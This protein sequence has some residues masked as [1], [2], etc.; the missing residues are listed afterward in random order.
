MANKV[1]TKADP[2]LTAI[3]MIHQANPS[4]NE[5]S[6]QKE[7]V[8]II[9][10]CEHPL[11]LN[12][13]GNNLRLYMPQRI[14]LK[15]FYRGDI[16]NEDIKIE[17]LE[18]KWLYDNEN[19]EVKDD[20]VYEKNIKDVIKKILYQEKSP[21]SKFSQLQLVLG[22]RAG[23]TLLAS[24]ITAY[25]AYKLL[26]INKGD[27]HGYYD[28][29][30]GD[31]IS[32][33]NVA[34]SQEQAGILFGAIQS[35]LRDSPFFQTR[36]ASEASDEIRLYTNRDIEKKSKKGA[37]KTYGSIVLKCGHS[38]PDSLAGR[39]A[40]LLLFDEIAYFDETGKVTGKYFFS[41]LKPSLSR[42]YDKKA[43]KI[44]QISSPNT[45]NGV[46]FETFEQSK[47]D[48]G[49]LSFQLPTWC[50][51][52]KVTYE[53]PEMQRDRKANP[54]MFRIEYGAQWATGGTYGNFFEEGMLSR[55]FRGDIGP[56][57]KANPKYNYYLHIDPAKKGNN[58]SAVL[59]A[60]D[61][62]ANHLGKRR[63]RCIL[64]NCWVWRPVPGVGLQFPL[65]DKDIIR[66]CSIFHPIMV[67]YDD[68]HSMH[69]L[70]LLRSH[71]I[72]TRQMP[73]NR[74]VKMKIYQNLRDLM[75]Y[76]PVPE[77]FLYDDGATSSLLIQELKCLKFKRTQRG[78]AITPDK[79]GDV[80]TDDLADCLAGACSAANE[81]LQM[82]LPE[83]VLVRTGL[84]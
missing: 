22:R 7:I 50:V 30:S 23:K 84:V 12:L 58:Y 11:Y 47:D 17:E 42:F 63:N 79:N 64:A 53:M 67:T 46:F 62:Y 55:T 83:P 8:D 74:N 33:I 77:L 52:E 34:L 5:V 80:K 18:W 14:I 19:D 40:I 73:F 78:F 27:P 10:F 75:T 16:G 49:T 21:K 41:R 51:N 54:D 59:V 39:S 57:E 70:Q 69:S 45:R 20:E 31:E 71:G 1:S 82:A 37:L 4:I 32:I 15:L 65:V 35:R 2:L 25:E 29:P 38:N 60:K 24:I 6:N 66:I 43:A 36:I 56:H 48:D 76:E 3:G 28:L 26:A 44:V 9:T 72:N 61:R 13:P 81:G 68:Y